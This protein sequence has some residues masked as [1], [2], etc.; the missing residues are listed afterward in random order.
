MISTRVILPPPMGH[1]ATSAG[2]SGM[3][4][5]DARDAATPSPVHKTVPATED[6]LVQNVK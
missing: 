2:I 6:Y 3:E 1:L 4:W 5:V